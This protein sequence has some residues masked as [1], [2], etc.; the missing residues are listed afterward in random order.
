VWDI[1]VSVGYT[2]EGGVIIGSRVQKRKSQQGG[3]ISATISVTV[4]WLMLWSEC[5]C[6]PKF[7]CWNTSRYW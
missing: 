6:F 4:I 7:L 1:T 2:D 3:R 5:L